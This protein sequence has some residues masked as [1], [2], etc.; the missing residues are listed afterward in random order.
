MKKL[1]L[2]SVVLALAITGSASASE[3]VLHAP[4]Q[5][6][7]GSYILHLETASSKHFDKLEFY[8]CIDGSEFKLLGTLP[9]FK[10]ISQMVNQNGVYG[11]KI[12]GFASDGTSE[13]SEPVFVNVKSRSNELRVR[14]K[15]L[16]DD[17]LTTELTL[18]AR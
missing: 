11:Y 4:E 1:S 14:A 15:E 12:R 2:T 13:F 5:S 17:K 8:R 10:A 7:D 6:T 9:V 3:L 16:M 18:S